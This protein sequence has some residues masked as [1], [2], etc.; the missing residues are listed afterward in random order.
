MCYQIRKKSEDLSTEDSKN[1]IWALQQAGVYFL[2]LTGGEP[3]VRK[4]IIEIIKYAK[5]DLGMHV[6][7]NTSCT[8][9]HNQIYD[10]AKELDT[11]IISFDGMEEN[12]DKNRGKGSFKKNIE[13]IKEIRKRGL[14]VN[15]TT[16]MCYGDHNKDDVPKLTALAKELN[17]KIKIYPIYAEAGLAKEKDYLLVPKKSTITEV[18]TFLHNQKKENKYIMMSDG[19]L[20]F[21]R[22]EK[23]HKRYSCEYFQLR[24]TPAGGIKRCSLMSNDDAIYLNHKNRETFLAQIRKMPK[25]MCSK[26]MI[27]CTE[28]SNVLNFNFKSTFETLKKFTQK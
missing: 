18:A 19:V 21:F 7:L 22:L 9:P 2:H 1:M 26:P 28:I 15:V 3:L 20:D 24:I 16:N 10:V 8:D 13:V 4:D 27:C 5:K 23:M 25:F 12:H 17:V 6:S 11:L 14:K